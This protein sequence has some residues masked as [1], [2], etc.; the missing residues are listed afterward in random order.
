MRREIACLGQKHAGPFH[1]LKPERGET[2]LLAVTLDECYAQEP[3]E[4]LNTARERGLRDKT[5]LSRLREIERLRECNEI[6]KLA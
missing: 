2:N 1:N 6:G 4:F 5:G 3:L